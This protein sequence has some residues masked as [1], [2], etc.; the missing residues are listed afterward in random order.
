MSTGSKSVDKLLQ[1][2]I[3]AARAG[4]KALARM[5]LGEVVARDSNNESAWL[6]FASVTESASERR[7]CLARVL[8]INPEN[9]VAK[10]ELAKLEARRTGVSPA[11]ASVTP[12]NRPPIA[13]IGG[14]AAI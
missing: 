2:G 1:E 14:I 12:G 10:R 8:E 11:F 13:V 9:A 7:E 5:R 4:N 6:W 3:E